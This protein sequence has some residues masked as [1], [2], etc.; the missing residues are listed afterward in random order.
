MSAAEV[1]SRVKTEGVALVLIG[2]RLTWKADHQPPSDLLA[3]IKAH[4]LE[5]IAFLSAV[6]DPPPASVVWLGRVATLLDCSADFLLTQGF[7]DRHDL[8]EQ[9]RTP[10]HLAARLIRSHPAWTQALQQT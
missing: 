6:N 1:L 9:Y 4:R 2:D 10:P 3:N 7:I 5:I 8:V